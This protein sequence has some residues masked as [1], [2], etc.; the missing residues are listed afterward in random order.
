MY[1]HADQDLI[2]ATWQA[3]DNSSMVT[4]SRFGST[5]WNKTSAYVYVNKLQLLFYLH[6]SH[7]ASVY[8]T[9]RVALND[10]RVETCI[11]YNIK[12]SG[13]DCI[14]AASQLQNCRLNCKLSLQSGP[15]FSS[16][17]K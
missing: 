4:G 8:S 9:I 13:T 17:D 6:G 7:E 1:D 5:G 14:R 2:P 3:T 15:V 16:N 11:T 10:A 12:S